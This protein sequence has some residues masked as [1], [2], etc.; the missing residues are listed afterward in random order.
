M[1]PSMPPA[2]F[3]SSGSQSQS[4]NPTKIGTKSEVLTFST[5]PEEPVPL[6]S[7]NIQFCEC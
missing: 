3:P 5:I 7:F 4:G 6:W 2:S 1:K